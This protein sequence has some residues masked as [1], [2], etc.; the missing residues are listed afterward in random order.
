MTVT[1]DSYQ[2]ELDSEWLKGIDDQTEI[3]VEVHYKYYSTKNAPVVLALSCTVWHYS[4][5]P[6]FQAPEMQPPLQSGQSP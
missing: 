6:L 4:E 2:L 1:E 3:T 5:L